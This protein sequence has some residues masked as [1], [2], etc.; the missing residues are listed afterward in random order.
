VLLRLIKKPGVPLA[1]YD[2]A[3]GDDRHE[4]D[5]T[6][7]QVAIHKTRP[8]PALSFAGLLSDRNGASLVIDRAAAL[9][10][11]CQR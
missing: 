1:P 2:G 8:P 7:N 3:D 4:H 9:D 10:L 6:N 5:D 11:D